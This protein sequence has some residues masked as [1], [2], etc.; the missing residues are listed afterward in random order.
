M[1]HE[2]GQDWAS[3]SVSFSSLHMIHTGMLLYK[4]NLFMV[5]I[6]VFSTVS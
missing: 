3:D 2:K 5:W 6:S 1:V 4:Q